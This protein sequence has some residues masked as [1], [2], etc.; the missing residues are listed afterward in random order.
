MHAG[1]A[2]ARQGGRHYR[3]RIVSKVFAGLDRLSR[4]RLVYEALG[5]LLNGTIHAL[6]V[7]ALPPEHFVEPDVSDRS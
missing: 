3:L 7:Q 2:G 4:Q 6:S 1:H 5:D